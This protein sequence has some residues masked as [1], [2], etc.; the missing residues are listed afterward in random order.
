MARTIIA[1]IKVQKYLKGMDY[2]ASK[3][4]LIEHARKNRADEELI[5]L[6][7]KMKNDSFANPAEVSKALGDVD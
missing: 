7:E 2:P 5:S 4:D 3:R 6:L 1:P